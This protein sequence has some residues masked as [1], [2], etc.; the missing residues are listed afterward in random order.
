MSENAL[1]YALSTLAQTCAALLAFIGALALY[2]LQQL[3]NAC[4]ESIRTLRGL[5]VAIGRVPEVIAMWPRA[6]ILDDAQ[7]VAEGTYEHDSIG[8]IRIKKEK[9][10]FLEEL[11]VY[12]FLDTAQG[13]RAGPT[14]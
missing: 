13:E 8:E 14:K 9:D 5:F 11:V 4:E 3:R 10:R 12:K 7:A 1:L 6:R 2:R